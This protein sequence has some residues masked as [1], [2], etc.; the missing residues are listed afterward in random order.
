MHPEF[1]ILFSF[2]LTCIT[3]SLIIDLDIIV[4][5]LLFA[6]E[7]MIELNAAVA[8]FC[9]ISLYG[10]NAGK[11]RRSGIVKTSVRKN[12]SSRNSTIMLNWVAV[13]KAVPGLKIGKPDR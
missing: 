13:D 8:I 7:E 10:Q 12:P 4:N 5:D 1:S 2:F 9:G 3:L 6:F 11:Q